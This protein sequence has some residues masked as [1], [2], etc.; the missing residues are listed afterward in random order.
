[1]ASGLLGVFTISWSFV[2]FLGFCGFRSLES[3]HFFLL[4]LAVAI[5][6][7]ALGSL[8]LYYSFSMGMSM[9]V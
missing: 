5:L 4:S 1:M 3:T 9:A 6:D 2:G 7:L 8:V